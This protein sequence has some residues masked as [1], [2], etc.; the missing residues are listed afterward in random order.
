MLG[1]IDVIKSMRTARRIRADFFKYLKRQLETLVKLVKDALIPELSLVLVKHHAEVPDTPR[2]SLF[3][4]KKQVLACVNQTKNK[5]FSFAQ[6]LLLF[7][8]THA[9][10]VCKEVSAWKQHQYGE[11]ADLAFAVGVSHRFADKVITAVNEGKEASFFSRKVRRDA[12]LVLEDLVLSLQE[13][14]NSRRCPGTTISVAYRVRIAR[15]TSS[16][17]F[18]KSFLSTNSRLPCF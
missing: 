3:R 18:S 4:Y 10:R 7:T 16:I 15:E 6:Q 14:R 1:E 11:V 8:I 2:T 5:Y 9:I 12:L 17:T 13:I